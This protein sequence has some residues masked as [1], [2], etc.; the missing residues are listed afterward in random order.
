MADC[1]TILELMKTAR[2]ICNQNT[3][4]ALLNLIEL[5]WV[6]LVLRHKVVLTRPAAQEIGLD[7][8]PEAKGR[9]TLLAEYHHVGEIELGFRR[10]VLAENA[11][12]R[13]DCLDCA[14]R[15]SGWVK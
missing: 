12:R 15:E 13:E 6:N 4:S 14:H 10:G 9:V 8:L 1:P 5:G 3:L 7:W 2:F 11:A